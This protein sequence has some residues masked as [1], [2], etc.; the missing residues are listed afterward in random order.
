MRLAECVSFWPFCSPEHFAMAESRW[1]DME[2]VFAIGSYG[3]VIVARV[4][5]DGYEELW[6]YE[7]AE[8]SPD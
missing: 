7:T 5:D 3:R 8:V 4:S 2:G 6:T 1:D